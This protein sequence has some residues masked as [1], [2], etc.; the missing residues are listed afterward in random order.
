MTLLS[1]IK[2]FLRREVQVQ[3]DLI[4]F[5]RDINYAREMLVLASDR[6]DVDTVQT[7][8]KLMT[9]IDRASLSIQQGARS[10][11]SNPSNSTQSHALPNTRTAA[12]ST[13]LSGLGVTRPGTNASTQFPQTQATQPDPNDPSKPTTNKRYVRGLR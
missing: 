7:A 10:A 13:L 11:A 6:G 4:R 2:V 9:E 8:L 1:K 12:N 3:L 5:T